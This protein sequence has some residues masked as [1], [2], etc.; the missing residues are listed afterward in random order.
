MLKNI[1]T[2]H[3]KNE[4]IFIGEV[5]FPEKWIH[6]G[7]GWIMNR[8]AVKIWVDNMK[9]FTNYYEYNKNVG[10]DVI[11]DEYQRVAGIKW[12]D[13]HTN[14]F[15]GFP[16]TDETEEKLKNRHWHLFDSCSPANPSQ[17]MTRAKIND[18]AVWHSGTASFFTVLHGKEIIGNVPD[19]LYMFYEKRDNKKMTSICIG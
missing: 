12:E 17:P 18:V 15:F 11:I 3:S 1:E 16:I 4:T 8:N 13:M 2:T 9:H 10:D 14:L 19:S 7:P 5:I 6:G